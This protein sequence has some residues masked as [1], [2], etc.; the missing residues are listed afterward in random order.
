MQL[1]LLLNN[2]PKICYPR[3]FAV[4]FSLGFLPSLIFASAALIHMITKLSCERSV[5][6]VHN[7]G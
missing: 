1:I 2:T 5:G 3:K 7:P 6:V 4:P